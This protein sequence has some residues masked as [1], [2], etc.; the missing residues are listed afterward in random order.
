MSCWLRGFSILPKE[1]VIAI[2]ILLLLCLYTID[3]SSI[4][5]N[6]YKE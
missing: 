5:V 1:S 2:S 3:K 6:G 4:F